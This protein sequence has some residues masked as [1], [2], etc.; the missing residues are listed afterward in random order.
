MVDAG[1][2]TNEGD[3]TPTKKVKTEDD[4]EDGNEE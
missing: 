3:D 1:A 2:E 4:D